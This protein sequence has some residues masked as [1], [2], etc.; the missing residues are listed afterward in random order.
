VVVSALLFGTL[1]VLTPLAYKSGAAP[2]PLL[3]WRFAIASALL[4]VVASSRSVRSLKVPPADLLR[5]GALAVTGYGAASI[6]YFFALTHATPSVVAVLLYTYPA[7]VTMASWA[8]GLRKPTW[9]QGVAVMVTFAGCVLVLDPFSP[10]TAADTL[11]V[12]LGLGA[13]VGYSSFNLLSH[14]WLPG[15]SRMVMMTYTFGIAAVFVA[16]VTLASGGSLSVV[17]WRP[18]VWMLLAAIVALPTFGAIVLYLEGIR[19][20]GPSQAALVSTLE[21]LFTIVLAAVVLGERLSAVQFAGAAL[22][23]AGVVVGEVLA[24]DTEE[25]A[26]V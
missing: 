8:L 1:A 24:R 6:C 10:G 26:A 3:A 9:W 17:A 21:P 14:R 11:G 7:L 5:Y 2:L 23:L 16:I 20:L 22:V 18:S 15:R 25:I 4:A 12:L 19:G 13:A